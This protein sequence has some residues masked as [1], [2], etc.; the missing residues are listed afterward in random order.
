VPCVFD[1]PSDPNKA[2][3]CVQRDQRKQV[4]GD[5]EMLRHCCPLSGWSQDRA[6]GGAVPK[7]ASLKFLKESERLRRF[8]CLSKTGDNNET[9]R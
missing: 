8:R 5:T 3:P 6:L 7:V 1:F 9:H 4:L 2:G